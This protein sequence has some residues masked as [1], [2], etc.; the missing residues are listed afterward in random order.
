MGRNGVGK[1]TLLK[2]IM[3]L[4]PALFGPEGAEL[5][6]G[7][8]DAPRAR[9]QEAHDGLEEGGLADAVPA[10]EADHATLRHVER[11]IPEDLALPVGDVQPADLK[12]RRRRSGPG[13]PP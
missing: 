7:Q 1:T 5:D 12:H 3:G 4:L 13:T 8:R 2:T 9:G 10:H 11:D 6:A